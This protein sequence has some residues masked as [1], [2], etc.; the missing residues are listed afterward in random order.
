MDHQLAC[1]ACSSLNHFLALFFRFN[2][3]I[4]NN[5][6]LLIPF[7]NATVLNLSTQLAIFSIFL[8]EITHPCFLRLIILNG[9]IIIVEIIFFL[10]R[11]KFYPTQKST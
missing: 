6:G 3:P 8:P 10:S 4:M 7:I 9:Y 5:L 1:V 2:L 11:N